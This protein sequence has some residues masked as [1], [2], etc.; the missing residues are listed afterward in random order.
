MCEVQRIQ[1]QRKIQSDCASCQ[2]FKEAS[3]GTSVGNILVQVELAIDSTVVAVCEIHKTN[4]RVVE[5]H[6]ERT[7]LTIAK[8]SHICGFQV[9]TRNTFDGVTRSWFEPDDIRVV[10]CT[11]GQYDVC[12]VNNRNCTR[13]FDKQFRKCDWSFW[14]KVQQRTVDLINGVCDLCF[15]LNKSRNVT[16]GEISTRDIAENVDDCSAECW[17]KTLRSDVAVAQNVNFCDWIINVD[18]REPENTR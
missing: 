9:D 15:V 1:A 2:C 13:H 8:W 11:F 17:V 18:C 4:A 5:F 10:D 12:I 14:N 3:V 6:A 16:A 7:L